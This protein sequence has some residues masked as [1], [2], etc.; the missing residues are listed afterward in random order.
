MSLSGGRQ[1]RVAIV[2]ALAMDPGA[3]LFDE[4]ASPPI[5]TWSNPSSTRHRNPAGAAR[6]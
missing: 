1:Q 5:R 2:R 4:V 3:I 6:P